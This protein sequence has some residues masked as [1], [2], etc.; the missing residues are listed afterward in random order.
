MQATWVHSF[1][2][3]YSD[4][5]RR[6]EEFRVTTFE[7]RELR[8]V[9]LE[10]GQHAPLTWRESAKISKLLLA[11][12]VATHSKKVKKIYVLQQKFP[13]YRNQKFKCIEMTYLVS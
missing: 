12:N 8:C 2:L 5:E 10:I 9:V 1:G 3:A 13:T 7:R 4:L 11:K 6:E